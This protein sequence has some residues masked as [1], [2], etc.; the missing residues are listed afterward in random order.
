MTRTIALVVFT[1][2]SLAALRPL[3]AAAQD[4]ANAF[5]AA[6]EP[7]LAA[8]HPLSIDFGLGFSPILDG[9]HMDFKLEESLSYHLS[10]TDEGFHLGVMLGEA[11]IDV[12]FFDV[13]ARA[14]YD[15]KFRIN[16][17]MDF[18]VNP[19]LG[20]GLGYL[21]FGGGGAG[22]SAAFLIQPGVEAKLYIGDMIYIFLRPLQFSIY[23]KDG[24]SSTY[25]F[26]TGVGF[27]F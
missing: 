27:R 9:G 3:P 10:G 23:I 21:T 11:F 24:T 6:P 25:D 16:A 18:G 12:F 14:G 1:A 7:Q 20:L 2:L 13:A 19:Y 5:T 4:A 15:F 26:L 22:D 17:N 8:H